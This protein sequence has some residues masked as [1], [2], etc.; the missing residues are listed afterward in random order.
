MEGKTTPHLVSG[1]HIIDGEDT[2]LRFSYIEVLEDL[3]SINIT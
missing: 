1:C 3:R 2:C